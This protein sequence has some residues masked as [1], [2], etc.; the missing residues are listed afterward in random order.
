MALI[1][2]K[3]FMAHQLGLKSLS[4][5]G[6][7]RDR[8]KS[9]AVVQIGAHLADV[10][11]IKVAIFDM[12]NT[13]DRD[14]KWGPL[15]F[16]NLDDLIMDPNQLIIN[17]KIT[18]RL[19]NEFDLVLINSRVKFGLI[20]SAPPEIPR[21]CAHLFLCSKKSL[22]GQMNRLLLDELKAGDH[23]VLGVVNIEGPE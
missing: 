16:F 2:Q 4:F 7:V 21:A 1:G 12:E 17:D 9:E 8:Q 3:I 13:I 15:S 5:V 18:H 10:Y 11:G 20:E 23:N 14:T 22:K 19:M 6:A